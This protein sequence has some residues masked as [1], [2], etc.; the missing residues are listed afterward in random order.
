MATLSPSGSRARP[1]R[2]TPPAA[3][4]GSSRGTSR[5]SRASS[6]HD[7]SSGESEEEKQ[8]HE[9]NQRR[10]QLLEKAVL[11][12]TA[13]R[14][15]REWDSFLGWKKS[16]DLP[17]DDDKVDQQLARYL[18]E[19]YDRGEPKSRAPTLVCAAQH[20]HPAL[21]GHLPIAWR[22]VKAWTSEEPVQ[23]RTPWP[24]QL[25]LAI[26]GLALRLDQTDVALAVSLMFHGLLR[27]KELSALQRKDVI[28]PQELGPELTKR[29]GILYVE[30]PKT[31]RTGARSQ[32]VLVENGLLLD[33]LTD[34]TDGRPEDELLFPAQ[35]RWRRSRTVCA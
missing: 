16:R 10:G 28:L 23:S 18:Q 24:A 31:R 11:R 2:R 5:S 25:A 21:R 26:I 34:F 19:L 33:M 35:R 32:H 30:S 14:Y 29:L 6:R 15:H 9:T 27:P 4:R 8:E 12:S 17:E 3:A 20:I 22:S 1:T 7:E 13:A